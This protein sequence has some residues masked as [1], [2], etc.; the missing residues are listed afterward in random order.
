MRKLATVGVTIVGEVSTTNFVPVPV[1]EA[2]DV[3][4]PADVIG[5]VRLAF[6]V[7]VEALPEQ[8]PDE[9]EQLPVTFPVK[10]PAKPVAVKSP[11]EGLK[12]NL[13][14]ET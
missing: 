6:V 1:W 4:F 3:A 9:P 12:Y 2:I 11:V 10:G 8:L 5:P 7:T 14:V 13:V